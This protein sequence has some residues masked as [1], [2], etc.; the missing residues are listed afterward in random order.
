[1]KIFQDGRHFYCDEQTG[2]LE[3]GDVVFSAPF[4][5][6]DSDMAGAEKARKLFLDWAS[7]TGVEVD[8]CDF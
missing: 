2:S 5:V 8:I 4:P 1:M 7:E 6:K 3:A